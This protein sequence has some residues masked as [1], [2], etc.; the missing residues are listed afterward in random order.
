MQLPKSPILRVRVCAE[1]SAGAGGKRVADTQAEK[2][3]V[4]KQ[5]RARELPSR[6]TEH[7]FGDLCTYF[8]GMFALGGVKPFERSLFWVAH[9][10]RLRILFA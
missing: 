7:I 2:A 1:G 5:M 4:A 8:C 6:N 9:S 10:F 3:Q